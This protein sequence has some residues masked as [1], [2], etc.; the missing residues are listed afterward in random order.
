MLSAALLGY[1][2]LI[3]ASSRLLRRPWAYR[4]PRLTIALWQSTL[5]TLL[6]AAALAFLA[7][8]VP[9]AVH[10]GLAGWL[11]V[12]ERALHAGYATPTSDQRAFA[13]GT[14]FTAVLLIRI[15]GCLTAELRR[16]ARNRRRHLDALSLLGRQ[17]IHVG[18]TVV[19]HA[20]PAAYCV[21]GR[22]HRIVVTTATLATLDPDQLEQVLAHERAHLSGR[23]DLV[24]VSAG[25]LAR[26]V[27]LPVIRTALAEMSILVEMLADDAAR[28]PQ[29]RASLASA[30]F[31][32]ATDAAAAPSAGLAAAD[33]AVLTRMTRLSGPD[34][35][36]PPALTT[37]VAVVAI[38]AAAAPAAI[39]LA[40]ALF[41][42]LLPYCPLTA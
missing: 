38:V 8:T 22:R 2:M 17:D 26:A 24:L 18:V 23:H 16:A 37:A 35:P 39:A 21:P 5:F 9:A 33:V 11:H 41:A 27:P 6:A 34:R 10:D 31:S 4:T 28:T 36:L 30:L 29:Q 12:C 3:T 25:A 14:G 32:V 19:E 7:L 15:G 1:A 13:F 20:H 40:P 42:S